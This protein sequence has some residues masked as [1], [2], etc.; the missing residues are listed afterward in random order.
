MEI[1]FVFLGPK[2]SEK[3]PCCKTIVLL[4]FSNY[5][6]NGRFV[7]YLEPHFKIKHGRV[8]EDNKRYTTRKIKLENI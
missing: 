1:S 2:I 3:W 8:K 7:R 5:K 6:I 4:N